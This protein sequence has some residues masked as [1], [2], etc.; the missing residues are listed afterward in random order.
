VEVSHQFCDVFPGLKLAMPNS[1]WTPEFDLPALILTS[2]IVDIETVICMLLTH[3]FVTNLNE[4]DVGRTEV[5]AI[6]LHI[7]TTCESEFH[8]S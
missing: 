5:P 2:F 7:D 6:C 4:N 8:N 1:L 3:F